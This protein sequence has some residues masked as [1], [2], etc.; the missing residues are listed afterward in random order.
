VKAGAA[1]WRHQYRNQAHRR[2]WRQQWRVSGA[3]VIT[4]WRISA[5]KR[6]R[7]CGSSV[8][9]AS[10]AE[11]RAASPSNLNV[12]WRRSGARNACLSAR[13]RRSIM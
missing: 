1:K 3:G 6:K 5:S 2:I 8:A 7:G 12:F 4:A 13:K 11:Q 9:G 10:A